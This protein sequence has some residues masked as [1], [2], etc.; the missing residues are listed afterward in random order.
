MYKKKGDW[1]VFLMEIE[2]ISQFA[3]LEQVNANLEPTGKSVLIPLANCKISNRLSK[4]WVY[5][6]ISD[7]VCYAFL[8]L[9]KSAHIKILRDQGA[10]CR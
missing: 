4:N 2:D 3:E 1:K 6:I 8:L 10:E 5:F 7:I 9:T